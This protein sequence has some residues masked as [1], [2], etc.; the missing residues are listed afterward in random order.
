MELEDTYNTSPCVN[1]KAIIL[2]KHRVQKNKF[3]QPQIHNENKPML[4]VCVED[5]KTKLQKQK[6]S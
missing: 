2:T 4:Y 5:R 1:L 6:T 3:A